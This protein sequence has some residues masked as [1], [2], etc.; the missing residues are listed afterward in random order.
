[1]ENKTLIITGADGA[2]GRVVAQKLLADGWSLHASVLDEKNGSMLANLFPEEINKSIF[3]HIADLSKEED[4]KKL[5]DD[6]GNIFGLVHLAGGYKPGKSIADHSIEDF[7]FLMGLNVKPTFLLLKELVPLLKENNSG[8]IV[9][10]GAKTAIHQTK[11]NAVYSA[12]KSAAIAISLS[13]AEECRE[14]NVRVNC[15]LPATL[16]T[17]NNLSWATEEEFKTF[18]PL[19]DVADMISFLM[20]DKS[21]GITGMAIPMYNKIEW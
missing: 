1:M 11:G 9:V 15:I 20:S 18:T 21:R 4:V 19:E 16:Q 17:K 10:I 14:N 8:S 5:V 6:S 13:V 2:L 3:P 12:S 7:D